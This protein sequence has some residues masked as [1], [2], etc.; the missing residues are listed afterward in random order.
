MSKGLFELL[1]RILNSKYEKIFEQGAWAVGNISADEGSFKEILLKYN[2]LDPLVAKIMSTSDQEVLKYTN[3]ALCNLVT[4]TNQISSQIVKKRVA[5]TALIKIILTQNDPDMLAESLRALLDL[6]DESIVQ[7]LIDS[8]VV[9]RLLDLIRTPI[10]QIHF[11]I[12]QLISYVTNGTDIQTQVI[13]DCGGAEVIF[14]LLEDPGLDV[15]CRRECLWIISNILVG[16][17]D[18]MKF[19][20]NNHK[21]VDIIFAHCSHEN[22]KVKREAIWSICNSTKNADISHIG[23]LVEKGIFNIFYVNLDM[24]VEPP[25]LK[26]ILEALNHILMWGIPESSEAPN[27]FQAHL[28]T[29]GIVDR[30][31]GLQY[32]A[33]LQ[34][35]QFTVSLI[36]KFFQVHD[37][38]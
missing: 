11:T 32:H 19:I 31:Q 21:W 38:F 25:V 6:T 28:E 14:R 10:R 27:K 24:Q 7:I 1:P 35:Y 9:Q 20:F 22:I 12:L 17:Y 36:E 26:T 34:V 30:L 29:S 15:S 3:W 18:Q 5:I 2:V 16:T 13:L 23:L 33:N 4:G 8:K 37:P